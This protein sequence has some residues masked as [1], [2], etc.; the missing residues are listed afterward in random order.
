MGFGKFDGICERVPLPLCS[1]V[2]PYDSAED[3][4]IDSSGISAECFA[5]NIDLANTVIFQVGTAF[6]NIAAL[7]MTAMMVFNVRSKY[8]AVGRKELLAFFYFFAALTFF[9]L[10][11]DCGVV[12]AA[13]K[14]Y[15]YFVSVQNGLTS[16]LCWCLMLNGFVGFQIYEDGTRLSLWMLRIVS[17]CGFVLTFIISLLTFQGWAGL[18]PDNTTALFVVLYILNAVALFIYAICQTV[19]VVGTLEDLWPLGDIAL[20]VGFFVVGQILLY[21][22]SNTLCDRM[23]HYLDGLFF[24]TLGNLF[25]VMMVYKFWDSITKEDLEFSVGA[26]AP[27]PQNPWDSKEYYEDLPR[28][29]GRDDYDNSSSFYNLRNGSDYRM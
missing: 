26:K 27:G 18:A 23:K 15:P 16:A 21:V 28:Q 3:N 22:F 8:T 7:A 11:V 20:G 2:G 29:Y 19:L 13:S 12:P 24:A 17:A 1:L 5:R 4:G 10:L 6:I 9:S 25:A 14:P